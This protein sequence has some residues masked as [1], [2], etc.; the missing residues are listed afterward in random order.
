MLLN[1]NLETLPLFVRIEIE[2]LLARAFPVRCTW[3]ASTRRPDEIVEN[4]F[5]VCGLNQSA[6]NPAEALAS[7]SQHNSRSTTVIICT[8]HR[9][10]LLKQCL[11]AVS[12][13]THAPD[14]VLV[15]D[16][17]EGNADTRKVAGDYR[18]DYVIEPIAGLS[19]ARNRGITECSTHI[20]AFLDDD[21]VPEPDWLGLLMAPFADQ[22]V[23]ATTGR[24]ITPDPMP[25]TPDQ[26]IARTLSNEDLHWFE[27][28]TFGG[29]GLGANM[30]LRKQACADRRF[31]DERL[32]RGAPFEIGE[33]SYAFALLLSRGYRIAYIPSAVVHHPPLTRASI[34]H[35]AE[36]S[37]SYWLLLFSTFP[38][39]RIDLLGFLIRRL[40]RKPL[41]WPRFPQGPGEIMSSG[42]PL[43]VK[44]AWKGLL[45]FLR[46]PNP[47]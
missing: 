16:N 3:V 7:P 25:P 24:V 30:A 38:R 37:F 8:R 6:N 34:E 21:V 27:I 29:M 41:D 14:R 15:V 13:L 46:T 1:Q 42:W 5:E 12:R 47:H 32:G 44:A 10:A 19:R 45:L 17:S 33:E 28:A 23:G 22:Q 11:A 39:Q 18:A 4:E 31:F 2:I 43:K 36:T 26:L 9:P 35:E 20:V 40:R